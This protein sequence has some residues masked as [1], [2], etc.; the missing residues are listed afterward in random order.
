MPAHRFAALKAT[1]RTVFY[2]LD[3]RRGKQKTC[4]AGHNAIAR[5]TNISPR[6]VQISIDRLIAVGLIERVGYDFGNAVRSHRGTI[7]KLLYSSE[8]GKDDRHRLAQEI[9]RA[10]DTVLKH[11]RSIEMSIEQLSL[12]QARLISILLNGAVHNIS[13]K[14]VP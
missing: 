14:S 4:T 5:A 12:A 10:I 3:R 7:Y 11:Q 9:E 6:Q 8:S 1:D 13:K 2:Y